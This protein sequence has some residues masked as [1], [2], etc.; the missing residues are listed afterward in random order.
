[1]AAGF[2]NGTIHPDLQGWECQTSTGVGARE[3][4]GYGEAP[5][6]CV[7]PVSPSLNFCNFSF[8]RKVNETR[9]YDPVMS[10]F[11]SV[12]A[13]V[14]SPDNSQNFNR[15]AYCLNNPLRYTDPSGWFYQGGHS[16]S[17][18]QGPYEC[19]W[20]SPLEPR[21]L[22]LR[23]L[24]DGPNPDI[25]WMEANDQKGGGGITIVGNDGSKTKYSPG[26]TYK[27]KDVYTS[28][29][30]NAL[31]K[32]M[33]TVEGKIIIERIAASKNTFEIKPDK[34]KK[35]N[36][37]EEDSSPQAYAEYYKHSNPE[38]YQDFLDHGIDMTAGSGGTI[39]WSS[40]LGEVYTTDG[41]N[42]SP[43]TN[44][45]H[46][47]K[48]AA[49]ADMGLLVDKEYDRTKLYEW[50]AVYSENNMRQA[51]GL[52]LRMGYGN[53]SKSEYHVRTIMLENNNNRW[54]IIFPPSLP[55]LP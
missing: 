43:T 55:W 8:K 4:T 49:D 12:D 23:Q 13:Y 24:P 31:N 32:L 22:G 38:A 17:S 53:D 36:R 52:P 47:L 37:F 42:T 30:V 28:K 35:G 46:E 16:G 40:Y 33:G 50:R 11:L 1:M 54:S 20:N 19:Q 44:L 5:A 10:S 15:Y 39:Y 45:G 27:G 21:D 41:T 48:H 29:V 7:G 51:L 2:T 6:M 26:M 14:Q 9:M 3:W 34:E 25:L 18:L